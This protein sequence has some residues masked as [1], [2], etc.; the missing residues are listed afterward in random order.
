MEIMILAKY[1]SDT[2]T[3]KTAKIHTQLVPFF[4]FFFF[5]LKK[6]KAYVPYTVTTCQYIQKKKKKKEFWPRPLSSS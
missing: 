4:F 3:N 5:L 6:K 2:S 1:L